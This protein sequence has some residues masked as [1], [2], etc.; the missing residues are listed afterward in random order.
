M[1]FEKGN[2]YG[3]HNKRGRSKIGKEIKEYIES[4]SND[5]IRSIDTESLT[6]LEKIQYVKL[7]LPYVLAKKKEIDINNEWEEQPIF[8]VNVL[9]STDTKE[10]LDRFEAYAKDNNIDLKEFE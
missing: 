8:E 2:T 9:D 10:R 6:D 4:L 3:K 7:L 1:A 5:L